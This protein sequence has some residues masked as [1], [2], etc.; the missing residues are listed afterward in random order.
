MRATAVLAVTLAGLA[1]APAPARAS[2]RFAL[3]VGEDHGAPDRPALWFAERD[4]ERFARTLKELGDFDE[5]NVVLLRGA[6]LSQ[7]RAALAAIEARATEARSL[8][9]HPLLLFYFSGHADGKGM[10]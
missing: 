2:P 6:P 3:V 7:V 8:G 9:E 10:E 1:L 4:A 5:G